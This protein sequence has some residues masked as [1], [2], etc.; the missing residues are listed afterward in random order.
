MITWSNSPKT[1]NFFITTPKKIKIKIDGNNFPFLNQIPYFKN[2][3]IQLNV[4]YNSDFY[5][6]NAIYDI[7]ARLWELVSL[8]DGD[9]F[10]QM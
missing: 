9:C 10:G 4:L 7:W 6:S 1:C 3:R 2:W 8:L 5:D